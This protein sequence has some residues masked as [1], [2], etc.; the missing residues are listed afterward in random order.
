MNNEDKTL[1]ALETFLNNNLLEFE[2]N[3]KDLIKKYKRKSKRLDTI[4]K[5]SDTQQKQLIQLNEELDTYKNHLEIKVEEEIKKREAKEK[6]LLQQSKLAAMGE[7]IDAVAHQWK[8]PINNINI[9]VGM[10]R[11]DYDDGLINNEYINK[12]ESGINAQISH[13]SDTLDEFRTFFRPDKDKEEFN[14][15]NMIEKVLLLIKDEFKRSKIEI[16]INNISDFNLVGIEN[17]FQHLILNILNNAKDAFHDN[18]VTDKKISINIIGSDEINKI[19]II[20]NAGGISE[21]LINNIFNAN[22]TTKEKGTGIGLYISKLI[23]DKHN[24]LL[25]VNNEK[26]G[27]KFTFEISS[28]KTTT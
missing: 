27:V 4:I 23:A 28:V 26:E 15:K 14:V 10:I 3:T 12:L 2:N 6:M 13:M 7:M 22:F 11:Y 19:E 5:Q 18:N 21:S 8:Q 25:K 1:K 24:G 17:E 16:T 9:Q 20:D